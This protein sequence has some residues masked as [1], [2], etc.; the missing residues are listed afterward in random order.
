MN[1]NK[2]ILSAVS[3]AAMMFVAC[4]SDSSANSSPS[5]TLPENGKV[6]TGLDVNNYLCSTTENQCEK[7][8]VEDIQV[9]MQCGA[10]G[11]WSAMVLDEPVAGCSGSGS[12]TPGGDSGTPGGSGSLKVVS[13]TYTQ[14]D[15]CEELQTTDAVLVDSLKNFCVNT[16]GAT[17]AETACAPNP[18][19][20]CDSEEFMKKISMYFYTLLYE[21]MTCDDFDYGDDSD[22]DS[23]A[24]VN[25]A[26]A[27]IEDEL[28]SSGCLDEILDP[29][30][31][32]QPIIDEL[33]ACYGAN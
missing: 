7:I 14:E 24:E 6:A 20:K 5:A 10:S 19:L 16:P 30:A 32:C 18:A 25:E 12:S 33:N 2:I 11:T 3:V 27:S 22:D 8:F 17:Y 31:R 29:S 15:Q 26:C 4:G 23:G 28:F 9:T 21:G 1:I 13:C